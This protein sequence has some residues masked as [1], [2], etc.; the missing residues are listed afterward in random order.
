MS[1]VKSAGQMLEGEPETWLVVRTKSRQERIAVSHL[2]QRQVEPYCPMFREPLWHRRA[3]KGP[4]PLFAGYIFVRCRPESDL[5]AVRFCPG[6]LV[7]LMFDG[8]LA[9]VHPALIENLRTREGDRGF[10]EPEDYTSQIPAGQKVKIM[11]GPMR[12]LEGVFRGYL[13]GGQRAQVLIEFLRTKRRIE[14]DVS[15]LAVMAS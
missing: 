14:V 13:R 6:V 4:V 5:N 8:E 3:P 1:V 12:G 2:G 11:G 15:A 7:P 9:T 10:I